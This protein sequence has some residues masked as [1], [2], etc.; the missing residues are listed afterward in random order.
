LNSGW[1]PWAVPTA[2]DFNGNRLE[3][4][5]ARFSIS[6]E[7]GEISTGALLFVEYTGEDCQAEAPWR[8][9]V[10]P[11]PALTPLL[12][13]MGKLVV[14]EGGMAIRRQALAGETVFGHILSEG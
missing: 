2:A 14:A 6:S 10:E 9:V 12:E 5:H 7:V 11:R 1:I 4:G 13:S 3:I 8:L